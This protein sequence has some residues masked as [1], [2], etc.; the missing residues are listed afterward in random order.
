MDCPACGK[1]MEAES[2]G[3]VLVDV[4]KSGC[5]GI[6]FDWGELKELDTSHKGAGKALDEALKSPRVNDAGH[7]PLKCPKCGI[8]MHAHKYR[9]AKEVNVDECYGCGGFFLDSGELREIREHHMSGEERDAYIQKL[10]A[11]TPMAGESEKAG[12][13]AEAC[14]MFGGLLGRRWPFIWP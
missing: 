7:G 13:R 4:C 1:K 5:K 9:S 12:L 8:V 6:W 14:R 3:N 11:D 10:V 2:F